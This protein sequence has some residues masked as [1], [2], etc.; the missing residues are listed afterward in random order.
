MSKES[1][2][3][4][5]LHSR[6]EESQEFSKS[7]DVLPG[8][9]QYAKM[10]ISACDNPNVSLRSY[11]NNI[12]VEHF[13]THKADIYELCNDFDKNFWRKEVFK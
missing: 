3:Q 4:E 8:I 6:E 12:L 11:L 13:K 2:Q 7:V 9:I 10:V 1:Y 5:F